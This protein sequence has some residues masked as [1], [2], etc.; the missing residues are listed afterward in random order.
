M[1]INKT[2]DRVANYSGITNRS[3]VN[4]GY[5]IQKIIS[6]FAWNDYGKPWKIEVMMSIRIGDRTRVLPNASL[7]SA[8]TAA[9]CSKV[10]IRKMVK[11]YIVACTVHRPPSEAIRDRQRYLRL[12][13]VG[14]LN[15]GRGL[16][17]AVFL[18]A[19]LV[20]LFRR[21][22][23][24]RFVSS[25]PLLGLAR[26]EREIPEKTHRPAAL[27]GT[28]PTYEIP[29]VTRLG[30]EPGSPWWEAS[31]LTTQPRRPHHELISARTGLSLNQSCVES[32]LGGVSRWL[33]SVGM[34][35]R[36]EWPVWSFGMVI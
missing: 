26:G 17:P 25:Y 3:R 31:R 5:G 16:W 7:V 27:S 6:A 35:G 15:D 22:S 10:A 29:G 19:R 12:P 20:R 11:P 2:A 30:V 24:L 18:R 8:T 9:P 1:P 4:E 36:A 33:A 28:I 21:C 23:T 14:N 32:I 34:F 13:H